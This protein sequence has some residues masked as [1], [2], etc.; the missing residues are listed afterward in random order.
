VYYIE[1]N[2]ILKTSTNQEVDGATLGYVF[3]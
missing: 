2:R 1:K 3:I